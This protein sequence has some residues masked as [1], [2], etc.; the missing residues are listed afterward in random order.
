MVF[1]VEKPKNSTE[2]ETVEWPVNVDFFFNI[3]CAT[4]SL[5]E[6]NR[7]FPG[8]PITSSGSVFSG[9][10]WVVQIS[11]LKRWPWICR[12]LFYTKKTG[13]GC[14]GRT[15]VVTWG[16]VVPGV[17]V[18]FCS[19]KCCFC[20]EKK[21]P[22]GR[23]WLPTFI[24]EMVSHCFFDGWL[25]YTCWYM[26][27]RWWENPEYIIVKSSFLTH[28]FFNLHLNHAFIMLIL[29]EFSHH[30]RL[31]AWKVS[32]SVGR[33]PGRGARIPFNVPPPSAVSR[34]LRPWEIGIP[35]GMAPVGPW[36]LKSF[37]PY[38][39]SN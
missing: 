27:N 1:P 36:Q 39:P 17:L 8:N 14:I 9:T 25:Y 22:L 28:P 35:R 13:S 18:H 31:Q 3:S 23:R 16:H 30:L 26:F 12:V 7:L 10:F 32:G 20:R 15:P 33:N 38:L 19:S 2:Q 29:V 5:H 21:G 4:M 6:K 11:T 24:S 34:P 37:H